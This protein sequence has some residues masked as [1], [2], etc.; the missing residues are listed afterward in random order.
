M[1]E[2]N[3]QISLRI[4]LAIFGTVFAIL[5]LPTV[6]ADDPPVQV[7]AWA[8][9]ASDT[10]VYRYRVRNVGNRTIGQW[11][12][13]FDKTIYDSGLA[14]SASEYSQL[15]TIPHGA[16]FA[17]DSWFGGT[18]GSPSN[19][20]AEIM[21]AQDTSLVYIEWSSPKAAHL[22]PGSVGEFSVTVPAAKEA[23][24]VFEDEDGQESFDVPAGQDDAYLNGSFTVRFTDVPPESDFDYFVGKIASIDDHAQS[25]SLKMSPSSVS[26]ASV[27]S[28]KVQAILTVSDDYDPQPEIKLESITAS[29]PMNQSEI[30]GA[31]FGTDD[32]L[33]ILPV[34]K[35]PTG[36]PVVYTVTY[37]AMDG[38][39]NKATQSA[40]V[41]LN[42]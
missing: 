30:K 4:C 41:T 26:K 31:V 36:K 28:L 20:I 21:G 12:L 10:L 23:A 6:A 34:K 35:D 7:E 32:R 38:T 16:E 27:T 25:L 18:I 42:P 19:W 14:D 40:T 15:L 9:H 1:T 5:S 39:G 11:Q 17:G 22:L 13:G 24:Y 2:S 33:F 8:E 3:H 29:V 37:S